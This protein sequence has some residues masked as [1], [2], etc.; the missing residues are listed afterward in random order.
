[1]KCFQDGNCMVVVNDDF[2]DLQESAAVFVPVDSPAGQILA[3]TGSVI[4]LPLRDLAEIRRRLNAGG[5][6]Y[7]GGSYEP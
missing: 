4:E 2:V 7:H 5:G 6:D 3:A 1:M